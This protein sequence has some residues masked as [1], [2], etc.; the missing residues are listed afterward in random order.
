MSLLTI[1]VCKKV[2]RYENQLNIQGTEA[3]LIEIDQ[4]KQ[5]GVC[6]KIRL[7]DSRF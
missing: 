4:Q 6:L 2:M 7:T 1:F 5:T 3:I